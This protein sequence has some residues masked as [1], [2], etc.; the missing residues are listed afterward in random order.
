MKLL[1]QRPAAHAPSGHDADTSPF[2]FAFAHSHRAFG[3]D[4]HVADESAFEAE[5]RHADGDTP[6]LVAEL[7]SASTRDADR[8]DKLEVYGR[9]VPVC[10]I[11]DMHTEEITAFWDP[12]PEG[13]RSRT[14]KSFGKPLWIP[15]RFGFDLGTGGSGTA[16]PGSGRVRRPVRRGSSAVRV[17]RLAWDSAA[18]GDTAMTCG[19]AGRPG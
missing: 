2:L 4:L 10:L 11:L 8:Q 9:T 15:E 16:R 17:T 5:G 12:S 7:T 6:S 14:T 13:C 18:I 19:D 1:R 3:P